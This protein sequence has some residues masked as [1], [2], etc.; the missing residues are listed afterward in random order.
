[1][2]LL[3]QK[4]WVRPVAYIACLVSSVALPP[5]QLPA[6]VQ[7]ARKQEM[8]QAAGSLL[9][10]RHPRVLALGFGLIQPLIAAG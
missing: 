3:F 2:R 4:T 5:F 8:D 9:P 10:T 6:N 1:M 7:C